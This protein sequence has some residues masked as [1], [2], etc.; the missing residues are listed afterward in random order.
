[1]YH[2]I[3]YMTRHTN[4]IYDILILL[5]RLFSSPYQMPPTKS[6][7]QAHL[8]MLSHWTQAFK[9]QKFYVPVVNNAVV[10]AYKVYPQI[11][12]FFELIE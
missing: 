3:P 12:T 5:L 6:N 1:M 9:E 10:S 2:M 8:S 7:L 4:S 11:N